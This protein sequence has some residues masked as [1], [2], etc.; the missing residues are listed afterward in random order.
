[1]SVANTDVRHYTSSMTGAS[2]L[3][4]GTAGSLIALIDTVIAGFGT[5]TL[6]S[7]TVASNIATATVSTG[8]GFA[9]TG[10][11]CGP[12][13]R[14]ANGSVSAINSDWRIASVPSLTTF[15]FNTTGIADQ[16]ITGATA[17]IA[18]PVGWS[19]LYSG[20]NK[21]V[22]QRS[23]T[24]ATAMVLRIDDTYGTYALATMYEAMSSVDAGTGAT[25]AVYVGKSALGDGTSRPWR[26]YI[27]PMMLYLFANADSAAWGAGMAFGDIASYVPGDAYHCLL[28]AGQSNSQ[29]FYLSDTN[30]S[31]ANIYLARDYTQISSPILASRYS[32]RRFDYSG[33]STG[34]MSL[35]PN[36]A[37]GKI[38]VWPIEIWDSTL[39]ARGTLPGLYSPMNIIADGTVLPGVNGQPLL[40]QQVV[41]SARRFAVDLVGPWR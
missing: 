16:T 31:A 12:V 6:S 36:P 15:T 34:C 41:E 33:Y 1:M 8:H 19:K 35:A 5:V 25:T 37:S 29:L 39:W 9:L 7:L 40:F 28:C 17:K 10:N 13:I 24:G 22:Y 20:T 23:T 26:L 4:N 18:P 11:Q 30:G 27:D 3:L 21:A 14:I 2:A 32:H 38:H